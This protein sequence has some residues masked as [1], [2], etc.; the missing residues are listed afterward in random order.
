M[1]KLTDYI[2]VIM[3]EEHTLEELKRIDKEVHIALK[4]ASPSEIK[5]FD[6]SGAGDMLGMLLEYTKQ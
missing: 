4:Q 5:E 3:E 1:M 6:E 2:N